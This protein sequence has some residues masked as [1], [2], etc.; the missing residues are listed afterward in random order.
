MDA[1]YM[2]NVYGNVSPT[3]FCPLA[4]CFLD[5]GCTAN[6][7]AAAGCGA[8]ACGV[9]G[10]GVAACAVNACPL[11]GCGTDGCITNFTPLPGPLN[12]NN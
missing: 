5:G 2:G 12:A 7:C 3:S 8:N 4:E 1:N 6:A 11:N 9:D 10:C